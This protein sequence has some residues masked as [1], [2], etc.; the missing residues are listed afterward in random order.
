MELSTTSYGILGLLALRPWTTYELAQQ[1]QRSLGHLW[2]V[3]ERQLY[4]HPKALVARG[5]ATA[6]KESTG[7][8]PRTVYRITAAGRRE[9]RRWLSEPTGELT[10]RSE[11]LVKAFFAEHADRAALLADIAALRDV[12]SSALAGEVA[13]YEAT[14][15]AGFPF[16]ERRH[17][18]GLVAR[19]FFEVG[20]AVERW[21]A[22]A[23]AEV[24]SWSDDLSPPPHADELLAEVY[25]LR[26]P[27]R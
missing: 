1:V 8:R 19:F 15:D 6:T 4:E 20:E 14:R 5:L 10:V 22:W 3:A 26:A 2:P 11:L 12:S 25:R 24:E 17:L 23:E 7:A 21:A 9:L 27:G 13:A 18:S 16:P